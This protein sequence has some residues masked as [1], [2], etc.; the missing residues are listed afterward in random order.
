MEALGIG[1]GLSMLQTSL[2]SLS[3]DRAMTAINQGD[4]YQSHEK[5][6]ES[7]YDLCPECLEAEEVEAVTHVA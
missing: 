5:S 1:H 3:Y 2:N 4:D 7:C 6:S